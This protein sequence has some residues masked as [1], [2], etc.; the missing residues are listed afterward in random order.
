MLMN[1]KR[2]NDKAMKKLFL[3]ALFAALCCGCSESGTDE[4]ADSDQGQNNVDQVDL[5]TIH[6]PK[7]GTLAAV[8][9]EKDLNAEMIV[10]LKITGEL[11]DEDFITIQ[12]M[13]NLIEIDLLEVNLPILFGH[14]FYGNKMIKKVTLPENLETIENSAFCDC[15]SLTTIEMPAGSLEAIGDYAFSNCKSLTS[16]EIPCGVETIGKGAFNDCKSLQTVIFGDTIYSL[17]TI[18][19]SVFKNCESLTSIQIPFKVETIGTSAFS[20]CKSLKTVTFYVDA[21]VRTI[22]NFAFYGCESLTGIAIPRRV[23]TIGRS[24]FANCESLRSLWVEDISSGAEKLRTIG[25]HA[26]SNCKSLTV[27][28]MST[29]FFGETIGDYAFCDCESLTTIEMPAGSLEAIGDYAFWNCKSLT[30]I[31]M[32]VKVET[33]GNYAFKG[34][35]SLKTVTFGSDVGQIGSYAFAGTAIATVDMSQCGR[36]NITIGERAFSEC[37]KLQLF[38]IGTSRPPCCESDAFWMINPYSVLKVPSR[39]I[40]A[41]KA[42]TGWNS[43]ASITG[44]DE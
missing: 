20:G 2:K 31:E 29:V 3:F 30:S 25:D 16:I 27:V 12:S 37:S 26:F 1:W 18:G 5:Y 11:N 28:D 33:I 41:Y 10:L 34:C 32:P 39:G 15:E 36:G 9:D 24:A 14:A 44:L 19:E 8:L 43:F 13:T 35:K 4:N 6:V 17:K 21:A 22:E 23:E 42:A 38:K 40:D 7:K